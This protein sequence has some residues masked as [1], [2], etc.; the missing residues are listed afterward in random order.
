M[1]APRRF[2]LALLTLTVALAA[3]SEVQSGA[4][5]HEATSGFAPP[6]AECVALG[7]TEPPRVRVQSPVAYSTADGWQELGSEGAVRPAAPVAF[8][9][10]SPEKEA[11][12]LAGGFVEGEDYSLHTLGGRHGGSIV[13]RQIY[14]VFPLLSVRLAS[15]LAVT[16]MCPLLSSLVIAQCTSAFTAH[17]C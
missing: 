8:Y 13:N 2:S 17:T 16:S 12:A 10:G 3:A 1:G 7:V 6:R 15:V 5:T 14:H 9:V 11:L 4:C